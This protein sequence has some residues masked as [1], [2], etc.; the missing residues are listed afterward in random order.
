M[1]E[2]LYNLIAPIGKE[3]AVALISMVPIIE[4]R[5]G[6]IVAHSL[7]MNPWLAFLICVIANCIP[8]PFAIWLTR[9]IFDRLKKTKLLGKMV[10]KLEAK[11]EKKTDKV[12]AHK[13]AMIGL[14][15]FVAIPLPGTG[16][17]T[18]ALVAALMGM[19]VKQA[20]PAIALGVVIAGL[21]MTIASM[22][23]FGA[24]DFLVQT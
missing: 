16:A 21:I 20:V 5:G 8:I 4:L 17:Y 13:N 9:P 23:V 22:G 19:R 15:I 24:L 10:H 14:I 7:E 18:G 2:W 12:K 1:A 11:L 3:A 6:I